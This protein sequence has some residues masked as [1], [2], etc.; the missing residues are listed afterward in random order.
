MH[1]KNKNTDKRII[2]IA[3]STIVVIALIIWWRLPIIFGDYNKQTIYVGAL[4]ILYGSSNDTLA[5]AMWIDDDCGEGICTVNSISKKVGIKP[6]Y[7]ISPEKTPRHLIDSLIMWQRNGAGIVIHGLRHEKWE[8]WSERH[9][10]K[11]I[12]QSYTKL[13]DFGF[14]T[15]KI[16]KIVVPPYAS[17]NKAI[18]KVIHDKNMQMITGASLVNPD[19]HVFQLGRIWITPDIDITSLRTILRNAYQQHNYVIFATHSSITNSFSE[20]KTLKVLRIAKEIGFNF[21]FMQ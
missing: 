11:D 6:V 13:K 5:H 3:M 18:R 8:E 21:D 15:S 4:D 19:R 16:L 14:D 1:N 20:E 17:N 12:E 9:I 10:S 7:A 2:M